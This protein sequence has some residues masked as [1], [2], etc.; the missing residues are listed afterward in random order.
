M[1]RIEVS[2][3]LFVETLLRNFVFQ[4]SNRCQIFRVYF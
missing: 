2:I 4:R 3:V 1:V